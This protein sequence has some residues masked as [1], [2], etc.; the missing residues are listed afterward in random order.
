M[1]DKKSGILKKND[2]MIMIASL[3]FHCGIMSNFYL[4]IRFGFIKKFFETISIYP[5]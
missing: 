4:S 5:V 2:I 3:A 1:P